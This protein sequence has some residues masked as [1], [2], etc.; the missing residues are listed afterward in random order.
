[1]SI[2]IE[3]H[4]RITS[5]LNSYSAPCGAREKAALFAEDGIFIMHGGKAINGKGA[6]ESLFSEF[7][8]AKKPGHHFR[9]H[10]SSIKITMKSP[11][12]ADVTSYFLVMGN[13]APDHWGVYHD[14]L[15]RS[16][17]DW[18]FS[19]RATTIEGAD[20]KGWIGSGATPVKINSS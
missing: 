15:I 20:P 5:T 19:K 9:H 17:D 8:R 13:T 4:I 2:D 10:L 7:D 11:D 1:M 12:E 16:N 18:L 6:I 3:S 14:T